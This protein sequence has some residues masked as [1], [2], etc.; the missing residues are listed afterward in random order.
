MIFN[1]KNHL[2]V[3]IQKFRKDIKICILVY[4]FYIFSKYIKKKKKLVK[5]LRKKT[6]PLRRDDNRAVD[7]F[8][9]LYLEIREQNA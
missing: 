2:F 5:V 3:Y 4:K 7:A 1:L 8:L 9:Y 6:A